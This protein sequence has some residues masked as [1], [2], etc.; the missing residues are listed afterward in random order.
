MSQLLIIDDSQSFTQFSQGTATNEPT[1]QTMLPLGAQSVEKFAP[2][3]SDITEPTA[4]DT[5]M[6]S[7]WDTCGMSPNQGIVSMMQY[8]HYF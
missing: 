3:S 1:V 5:L 2:V 4:F 7:R 8:H 6:A